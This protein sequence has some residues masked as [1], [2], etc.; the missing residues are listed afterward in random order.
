M[1]KFKEL[2]YRCIDETFLD[3]TYEA[4]VKKVPSPVFKVSPKVASIIQEH[5]KDISVVEIPGQLINGIKY[6]VDAT[7]KDDEYVK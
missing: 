3:D 5:Y 1:S 6:E 7:L 2:T 4:Q